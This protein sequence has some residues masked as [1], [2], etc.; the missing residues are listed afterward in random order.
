MRSRALLFALLLIL[1][2]FILAPAS[3]GSRVVYSFETLKMFGDEDKVEAVAVG[4][5]DPVNPGNEVIVVGKSEKV[6][7]LTGSHQS[8]SAKTIYQDDWYV[9]DVAIG[10][11]YPE[12]PGDEIVIC[13]WSNWVTLLYWKDNDWKHQVIWNHQDWLYDVEVCDIYPG[14]PGNEVVVVGEREPDN[15]NMKIIYYENGTWVTITPIVDT[16]ALSKLMFGDHDPTVP[17]GELYVAGYSDRILQV[18]YE[19]GTWKNKEV[20]KAKGITTIRTGDA[21]RSHNGSEIL[22]CSGKVLYGLYMNETGNWTQ[23]KIFEDSEVIEGVAAGDL[24]PGDESPGNELLLATRSA[25]GIVLNYVEE[26]DRWQDH[27]PYTNPTYLQGCVV[28]DFDLAHSGVEGL[29]FGLQG[30]VVKIQYEDEDFA[31]IPLE[32]DIT[33]TKGTTGTMFMIVDSLG[34]YAGKVNFAV[35]DVKP[36]ISVNLGR[37]SVSPLDIQFINVSAE[38][39]AALK[40]YPF[41]VV[42]SSAVPI[43]GKIVT[44][45]FHLN[46]TVVDSTEPNFKLRPF[47]F[48]QSIVGDF[49]FSTRVDC[50]PLGSGGTLYLD[51]W[52]VPVSTNTSMPSKLDLSSGSS[53]NISFVSSANSPPGR[54]VIS[55]SGRI[56]DI[57]HNVPIVVD[58]APTGD[59]DYVVGVER[60]VVPVHRNG[61]AKQTVSVQSIFGYEHLVKVDLKGVPETVITYQEKISVIPTA[62]FTLTFTADL[63]AVEGDHEV[64]VVGKSQGVEKT[65]VFTLQILPPVPDLQVYFKDPYIE[66]NLTEKVEVEPILV[67]NS[68]YNFTGPVSISLDSPN[69]TDLL[70][71]FWTVDLAESLEVSS[72]HEIPCFIA[73]NRSG[74]L[75]LTVNVSD[76]QN[77]KIADFV[78]FVVEPEPEVAPPEKEPNWGLYAM[79]AIVILIVIGLIVYLFLKKT[80]KISSEN[81]A[82]EDEPEE[83]EDDEDE[84]ESIYGSKEERSTVKGKKKK[85]GIKKSDNKKTSGKTKSGK[86]ASKKEPKSSGSK[87]KPSDSKKDPSKKT[88]G[89]KKD[90]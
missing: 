21:L 26:E 71:G 86:K 16:F 18:Y 20:V 74:Y 37:P 29:V 42:A 38:S 83:D 65:T 56:G 28:G 34:G 81:I 24:I 84:Y 44:K 89:K 69:G 60:L 79:L 8:W 49:S 67:I 70:K 17:G 62:N 12:S 82:A 64:V 32:D 2:M 45:E 61:S 15:L 50:V 22:Y 72:E 90:S 63:S 88:S 31:V 1:P 58:I 73:G 23:E 35:R 57:I 40:R 33:V 78:L 25:Y 87:M 43:G 52:R 36:G 46:A 6:K 54:Y 77:W 75:N 48:Y 53:F 59:P 30:R 41:T 19:N 85:P 27:Y 9:T 11:C 10:D 3:S 4:D 66:V 14:H 47:S 51:S 7:M 13:G 80:G 76:G 55:V 5:V 39:N 68:I